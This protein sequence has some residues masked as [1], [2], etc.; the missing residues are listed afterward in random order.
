M[1]PLYWPCLKPISV[2]FT[3]SACGSFSASQRISSSH[4]TSLPRHL[5]TSSTVFLAASISLI[6][7]SASVIWFRTESSSPRS[8]HWRT[9][10]TAKISP[11]IVVSAAAI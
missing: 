9:V 3:F 11:T 4:T 7:R 5:S 10:T 2:S 1:S 6:K 8:F